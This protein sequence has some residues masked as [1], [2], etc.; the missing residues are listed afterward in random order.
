MIKFMLVL[1][2]MMVVICSIYIY[3]YMTIRLAER[4]IKTTYGMIALVASCVMVIA[5]PILLAYLMKTFF[6][7]I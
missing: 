7:T 6:L 3:A 5:V 4:S 2:A 1:T